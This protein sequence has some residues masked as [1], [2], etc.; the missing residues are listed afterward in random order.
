MQRISE[1]MD[2]CELS[3]LADDIGK[4]LVYRRARCQHGKTRTEM[5]VSCEGG[6]VDDMHAFAAGIGSIA[7]WNGVQCIAV[8]DDGEDVA[9][10]PARYQAR[11]ARLEPVEQLRRA[12]RPGQTGPVERIIQRIM[13]RLRSRL[14]SEMML[15]PH[16]EHIAT[17]GDIDAVAW[18]LVNRLPH[19][20]PAVRYM[21]DGAA[22]VTHYP[23]NRT[24]AY[25][26]I[27]RG[28]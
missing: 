7:V 21:R 2:F 9:Y 3:R 23:D 26:R 22:W 8:S 4:A 11:I 1:S 25:I 24:P 17:S 5:C 15:S 18:Y 13:A 14:D 6:Y 10:L 12:C 19:A 28:A 27:V 20:R 16:I